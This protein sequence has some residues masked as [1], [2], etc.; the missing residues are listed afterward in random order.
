[1]SRQPTPKDEA[2]RQALARIAGLAF[3]VLVTLRQPGRYRYDSERT[4]RSWLADDG[5]G[6]TT[7]DL[8]HALALLES[9][10]GVLPRA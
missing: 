9:V 6:H 4:L 10:G 5:H 2:E 7:A 1:V 3:R 8:T